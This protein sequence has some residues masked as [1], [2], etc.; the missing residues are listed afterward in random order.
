MNNLKFHL[1]A[2]SIIIGVISLVFFMIQR[3]Q[4]PDLP[5]EE[6][7]DIVASDRVIFV[8]KASFG[9]NCNEVYERFKEREH[10]MGVP[11]PNG[12]VESKPNNALLAIT[13]LCNGKKYCSFTATDSK[14]G[15]E[16]MSNCIRELEVEYRCF[17]YDRVWKERV[18]LNERMKLQCQ[19]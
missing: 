3:F 8:S 5:V 9:L 2:M 1:I 6:Q 4:T 7:P 12:M 19:E 11:I 15:L 17:S 14:F 18:R 16:P 13:E 10:T